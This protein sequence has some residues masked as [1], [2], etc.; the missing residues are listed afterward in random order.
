LLQIEGG[1][2]SGV[3]IEVNYVED[4]LTLYLPL[5]CLLWVKKAENRKKEK[6]DLL[7]REHYCYCWE[8]E[9]TWSHDYRSGALFCFFPSF[10][11]IVNSL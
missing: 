3:D 7:G 11:K 5:V 2:K 6:R 9:K 8:D 1:K 4:P 10:K